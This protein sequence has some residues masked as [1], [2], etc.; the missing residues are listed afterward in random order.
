MM[1]EQAEMATE[2][3]RLAG[4]RG[5]IYLYSAVAFAAGV[6]VWLVLP[7]PD[8]TGRS[9]SNPLLGMV[10][11]LGR[12][13]IWA[14]A[15]VVVTAY[16]LFKGTD[17]YSLYAQHALGYN[18]VEAADLTASGSYVRA[19]AAFSAGLL[20][21]RFDAARSVAV[22]F[23]VAAIA[24]LGHV[25]FAPGNAGFAIMVSNALIVMFAVFAL[26]GIYFALLED[27]DTPRRITGAAVGLV[28]VVGFTPDIFFQPIA[29]RLLD[30]NPGV[31]GHLDLF[32]L[33]AA[34][35]AAGVAATAWLLWLKRHKLRPAP[36]H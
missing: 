2:A 18:E 16:C 1:P 30:A 7:E 15:L 10:E 3:E 11:V 19:I 12:P 33:L 29:G 8:V 32:L 17:Y 14:Q 20:A 27:T 6:L 23:G 9:R 34:I 4:M 13:L 35:S 28:S 36:A 5:L 26:R 31:E 22:A 25:V 21:D 24:F